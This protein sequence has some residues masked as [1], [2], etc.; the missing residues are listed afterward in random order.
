MTYDFDTVHH[1]KNT[2][3]IKYDSHHKFGKP[4]GLIPLWVADMDFKAPKEVE[5]ALVKASRHGIFGYSEPM[6]ESYWKAVSGWFAEGFEYH[7]KVEWL[8][9]VPGIVFATAVA[10]RACTEIGESVMIQRPVYHPFGNIVLDNNRKL[11]NSPLV[12][13]NGTYSIDFEDFENKIR[14]N[15]VKLF[16]LCSPHNPTGRVWTREELNKMGDICLRSNCV[17][18]SDEIHC[19]FFYKPH[20]HHVFATL[21]EELEEISI[22]ATAP[23]K[24]FNLPGLQ[25]SNIFISNKDL[26]KKFAMELERTGYSH[27]NTMG[28]VACESAYRCGRDWLNQLLAYLSGNMELV[29]DFC[30]KHA[31]RA[32]PL[33]GTYLAWLDFSSMG[34]SQQVL[35]KVIVEKAGLWLTTG[36]TFG[37]E[38]GIGFQRINIACPNS[39]LRNALEL[40]KRI[41]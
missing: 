37:A 31:I 23:S 35:D 5:D 12:Y 3:S 27:L 16:I 21:K 26:R 1:R 22:I 17:V 10:V 4:D 38:E 33:E 7:P 11:V 18:F 32:V 2:N 28:L 40:L 30:E 19:D 39:I 36:T 29:Y 24:T 15:N 9:K 34:L 13:K 41:F 8:V 20:K 14:K 25:A 6:D